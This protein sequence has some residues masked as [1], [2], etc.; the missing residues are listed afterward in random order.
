MSSL[1]SGLYQAVGG[2]PQLVKLL[3]GYGNALVQFDASLSE[4]YDFTAKPTAFPVEDGSSISDHVIRDPQ[5]I[6]LVGLVTDTPLTGA[7]A[8]LTQAATVAATAA[9]PPLGIVA[10]SL[11]YAQWQ[12]SSKAQSPSKAAYATLVKMF[13]G[14]ETVVPPLRPEPFSMISALGTF[15]NLVITSLSV[16][17]DASTGGALTFN[18]KMQQVNVVVPQTIN[19]TNLDKPGLA[20]FKKAVGDVQG[21]RAADTFTPG[22]IAGN[23]A[24]Y[25]KS[26]VQ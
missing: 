16:P 26:L 22:R 14:D 15:D 5:A 1:V 18:I 12:V 21:D 13:A 8:L 3:D 6:S 9:L 23:V 24:T 19:V 2:A 17:R 4:S 7:Q 10:A 11:A 20:S 25:G